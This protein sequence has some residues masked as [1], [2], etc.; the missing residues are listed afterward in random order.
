[1]SHREIIEKTG[2]SPSAVW[3]GLKRCW[4]DG[5]ILRTKSAI[6][7]TENVFRGRKG[8]VSTTRPY[9]LYLKKPEDRNS[10]IIEGVDFVSFSIE[11]L[12][13]RARIY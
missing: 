4:D 5:F 3:N 8:S 9:H 12:D 7:E 10:V 13:P 1:M 11:Y 6:F 2:L